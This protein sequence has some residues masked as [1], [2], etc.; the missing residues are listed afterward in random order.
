MNKNYQLLL[1]AIASVC[2]LSTAD[3]E[4]ELN[5]SIKHL[6]ELKL[7][8]DFR[9]SDLQ[10]QCWGLLGEG[11]NQLFYEY[12]T[13][14]LEDENIPEDLKELHQHDEDEEFE[15]ENEF[16]PFEW[17][18]ELGDEIMEDLQNMYC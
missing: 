14:Q 10:D 6:Q 3:A 16:N 1:A 5:S 15:D 17:A 2:C 8:N 4:N 13:H 7:E 12:A 18:G 9:M 11:Y